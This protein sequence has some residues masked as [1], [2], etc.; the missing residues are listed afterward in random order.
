MPANHT[1][2]ARKLQLTRQ[3]QRATIKGDDKTALKLRNEL[4]ALEDKS[5]SKK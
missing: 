1:F 2:L 4:K 5:K 3:I